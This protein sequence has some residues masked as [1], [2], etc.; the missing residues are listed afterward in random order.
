MV[1]WPCTVQHIHLA[2]FLCIDFLES[3]QYFCNLLYVSLVKLV[4]SPVCFEP[5]AMFH[6]V[7]V[8]NR[9][10]FFPN[11]LLKSPSLSSQV[12]WRVL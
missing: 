6:A 5:Y 9:A 8:Q 1:G 3:G 7:L 12:C 4:E 2:L 10:V 11:K